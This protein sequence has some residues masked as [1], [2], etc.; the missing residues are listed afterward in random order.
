M[1]KSQHIKSLKVLSTPEKIQSFLNSLPF[2]FEHNGETLMSPARTL[3]ERK[4]HCLEGA[5][6][7][8]AA[9]LQHGEKPLLLDLKAKKPDMDH[10]VALFKRNGYWGALSKT[11]HAV[12]RYREP[13]YKT[14]R[15][16]ALSYFHE[17][18]LP[19]GTKTL[20][21]FSKPF[22]LSKLKTDWVSSKDDLFYIS[23]AL[24]QVPH[25]QILVRGQRLRKADAI[26]I[27][28]GE[29]TEFT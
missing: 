18:F 24:D 22:D 2:N 21:S 28:A 27:K 3:L 20:R 9:L 25:E 6:L 19:D 12:L 8:A 29:I 16:L 26:E 13:V 23:R 1:K 14:V 7:A 4:A 10:V 17:Y 5:L 11:N 15:E